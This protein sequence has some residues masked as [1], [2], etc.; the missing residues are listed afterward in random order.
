MIQAKRS[1]WWRGGTGRRAVW[2]SLCVL[3]SGRLVVAGQAATATG[4][5]AGQAAGGPACRLVYLV[6]HTHTDIGY[7][8]PQS[9]ILPEHLR[10]IDMALDCCDRTDSYPEDAKF[11]WTCES[12]WVVEEYLRRRPAEQIERLRKRV[13]EGRIE[14]TAMR[15]NM[16]EIATESSLAASLQAIRR[17]RDEYGIPVRL[18][19]Q[20]DVNG[21]AWCLVDYFQDSG[22]KY[23]TM[24]INK[25]RS[26]LPFDRPTVFWWESPA[27]SRTLAFR[28]EHYHAGNHMGVNGRDAAVFEKK[29][30]GYLSELKKKGYPFER[31]CLQY[32]GIETDNSPPVSTACD[33]IRKWNE[34]HTGPKLR[35]ATA[36]E[37][38]EYVAAEYADTLPV[39]RAA[40]PDWWTDG[41]GSAARETAK[42]R[43]IHA[44]MQATQGLLAMAMLSG[45]A[46][47]AE[48][49]E[50]VSAAQEGVLF[51]DEHTYGA[52]ESISDPTAESTIVQWNE[53]M[54]YVW[55]AS[56]Q[57]GMLREEALGILQDGLPRADGPT[58]VVL[59]TLNWKRSEPTR[60]FIDR[61]VLPKE[62]EAEFV[63]IDTGEKAA[64]QKVGLQRD[65]A[66]WMVW[67]QDVPPLGYRSYRIEP[68]K[69][70]DAAKPGPS[71]QTLESDFYALTFDP[72][73]GAV[74]SVK[75]KES[76]EEL[77][78]QECPWKLGQ[79]IYERQDKRRE[80]DRSA[81]QRST[82]SKVSVK[83][84]V[85]GAVFQS[86]LVEADLE[87][88]AVP[89]SVRIEIR[90][91]KTDKRIAFHYGL[92]KLPVTDPEGLYVAF[93]FRRPQGK[94]Y[95]EAQGGTL[96]P[97]AG[98]LPG[99][100]SD[101]HTV[102]SFVAVRGP[103]GQIVMSSGDVP[104]VQFGDLNA[105]KWQQ[106]A[107]V[108]RPHVYSWV[109]N[110]YWYTN[111]RASQEGGFPWSYQLTSG[112][113]AS[114]G[115]AMR[116][117]W[118]SRVPLVARVQP[119]GSAGGSKPSD[120]MLRCAPENLLLVES[121]PAKDGQ[122]IILHWREVEG[123]PADFDLGSQPFA[124][125]VAAADEV[126]VLEETLTTGIKAMSFA[127]Y[128][129]KFVRIL[130]K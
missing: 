115:R 55:E 73:T 112:G 84:G 101:W 49:R 122:G 62:D 31:V 123:K 71:G 65:G 128:E 32:S 16:S 26:L 85:D 1:E 118:G 89:G 56:K 125:R 21:A 13:A 79:L 88:C 81:F 36:S 35:S 95:Y 74:V 91:Y 46:V 68:R 130:L 93:P 23:L 72:A 20:N 7:T 54:A 98:Q 82:V 41:F 113:D 126:N 9:E 27:G 77:V 45:K 114:N 102:Q 116:F 108:E 92:R 60:V 51:Y 63:A 47:S 121:R 15:L 30:S 34:T 50:R 33:L 42:S 11:R 39:Y 12:L 94:V 58:L 22:I 28:G 67:T 2:W 14:V 86:M 110:N 99:S 127:P 90:L 43:E 78:D 38:M 109:M 57:A 5:S 76:G 117:G 52:A 37:F 100:S 105:G 4:E 24:G 59:N 53:K 48:V 69:S 111:F 70:V 25:T 124:G 44:G 6:Q 96:T 129:V 80:F 19:M 29:L 106:V 3:A 97:G 10:F 83:P 17:L 66:N 103:Q 64:A 61:S 87:G 107:E 104:L 75:D 120:S 8:R 119:A 40:W 18:A